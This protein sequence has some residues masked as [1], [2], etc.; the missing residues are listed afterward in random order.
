MQ[1]LTGSQTR[2]FPP[3]ETQHS[4]RLLV[5]SAFKKINTESENDGKNHSTRC[6]FLKKKVYLCLQTH[7]CHSS[8]HPGP[9]RQRR[10]EMVY[11]T[12]SGHSQEGR[13]ARPGLLL[14]QQ[15]CGPQYVNL[16]SA[17]W[18]RQLAMAGQAHRGLTPGQG[19]WPAFGVEE[20]SP[21]PDS[22]PA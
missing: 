3:N 12:G 17:S 4:T 6:N 21:S 20:S 13:E 15:L 2:F 19:T 7:L 8:G 16:P 14:L 22:D 9:R 1:V 18:P 10:A 11:Q 5:T